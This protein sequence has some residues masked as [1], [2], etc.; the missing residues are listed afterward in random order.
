MKPG[1]ESDRVL[2]DHIQQCASRMRLS[3]GS[4]SNQP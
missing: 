3:L 2:L 4:E 1:P